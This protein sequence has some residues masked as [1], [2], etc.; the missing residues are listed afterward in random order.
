MDGVFLGGL[1][2][3]GLAT[4]Q[5]AAV[6]RISFVG[7]ALDAETRE[8]DRRLADYLHRRAGVD[9]APEELEYGQVIDRL[10][11]WS[12]REGH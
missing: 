9:F 1:M 8:A 4:S 6:E 5:S 3:L 10:T 12:D 7:V 11:N 2:M